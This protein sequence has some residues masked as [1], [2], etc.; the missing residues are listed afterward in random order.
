MIKGLSN[1]FKLSS[2]CNKSS[3]IKESYTCRIK[4][5]IFTI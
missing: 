4:L 5:V 3:L 2:D 1:L